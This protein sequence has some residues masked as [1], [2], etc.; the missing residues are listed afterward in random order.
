[1]TIHKQIKVFGDTM[2]KDP[3]KECNEFLMT[4]PESMIV[5]VTSF[6]NTILGGVMHVVVY[7]T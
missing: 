6:Y 3:E 2:M 7:Y 5:S 1:M 4:L